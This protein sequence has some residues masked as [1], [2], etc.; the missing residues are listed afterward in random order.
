MEICDRPEQL[1]ICDPQQDLEKLAS[2][3]KDYSGELL[4]RQALKSSGGLLSG[5]NQ[6]WCLLTHNFLAFF[7]SRTDLAV[8]QCLLLASVQD[9]KQDGRTLQI[10]LHEGKEELLRSPEK[11][12]MDGWCDEIRHRLEKLR[13]DGQ[14]IMPCLSVAEAKGW[15]QEALRELSAEGQHQDHQAEQQM[16]ERRYQAFALM[17]QATLLGR[18][19][20]VQRRAFTD[21]ALYSRIQGLLQ[22][23]RN[24][25]ACR[26]WRAIKQ[27]CWRQWE[28][29]EALQELEPQIMETKQVFNGQ[30]LSRRVKSKLLTFCTLQVESL[31]QVDLCFAATLMD[32]S[33]VPSPKRRNDLPVGLEIQVE[34][35]SAPRVRPEFLVRCWRPAPESE[36]VESEPTLSLPV[37]L[38]KKDQVNR[39][40]KEQLAGWGKNGGGC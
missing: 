17:L 11:M 32:E 19:R 21:L 4:R 12:S 29:F 9:V 10:V 34:A 6:E 38:A 1:K 24:A 31:G 18:I 15:A 5:W 26:L 2:E 30:V 25:A 13:A 35:L 22:S 33:K 20:S 27:P 8:K 3:C 16:R 36:P 7:V 37:H 39:R 14:T 28:R 40:A 23:Q